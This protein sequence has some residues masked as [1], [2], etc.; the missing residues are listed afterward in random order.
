MNTRV[1]H[2]L[3]GIAGALGILAVECTPQQQTKP[4][5][6][7][8]LPVRRFHEVVQ[9]RRLDAWS[10]IGPGGGGTFYH[11]AIS[12][13]DPNLVFATTDMTQCF[14]S[15][16]GGQTWRQFNLRFTCRFAFDP[17]RPARVYALAGPAGLWRSDDRGHTWSLVYPEPATVAALWYLDDEGEPNIQSV[18]GYPTG[19]SAFAVDPEDSDTLY[20]VMPPDLQISRDAGKHWKTLVTKAGAQTIY[21]D[22]R[23]PRGNRTLY[24]VTGDST[25]VWDGSKY[26]GTLKIAGSTW[27]YGTGFGTPTRGGKSVLYTANDYVVRNGFLQSGGILASEDGGVTWR[28]LN[29]GLLKLVAPGTYPEFSALAAS[30]HHPE[31]IYVSFYH[32]YLPNDKNPYFGV[33]KT[34]DGGVTW[35]VVR[36]E[37]GEAADNMHDSWMTDRFGPDFGDQPLNIAVD[38][39][40]PDLVYTSD[41]GRLMRST[42]GGKSWEAVYSQGAANGYTTTGLDVATCYGLH[43]DPFDPR[44]MFISYTDIGLFRSLDGS[45]SWMSATA[46]GVP[47]AWRNTTYWVEFDPAVKG[48]MWAAMSGTHDLPRLRMFHKP[49]ATANMRGGVMESVD[50]G[51]TWETA[52]RGLPEMA[53]THILLDPKSD[54]KS[55]VLYVTGF[56]RGVFKSS[57]GGQSWTAKSR[58]LPAKEPLTWRMAMD[59]NGVLYMVT[60]RRSQDGTYGG[61]GDGALYRSRDGAETWERVPVPEGLNGPM[62]I[63]PDPRDADRLYLAAWGRY[64]QYASG[65]PAPLGGV[66]LS[67][68]GGRHWN[69]VL[70]ASRRIYDVTLDPRNPDVVYATGFE[71]S[72]WRSADRGKTWRRI[73]GFNFKHGHRVIPDPVDASKIYI[74]TFGSSVWHGPAEGDPRAVEDIVGPKAM[75]FGR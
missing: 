67:T 9:P 2:S 5:I 72:A 45:E 17:H 60:V 59:R 73:R 42:N 28:S 41:L 51:D 23:S 31:V 66:F 68:D 30:L 24:L 44:R 35:K 64:K 1:L 56:G 29:D 70:D 43:F 15:E 22:P 53:A 54:P 55:R 18:S 21:V 46:N 36:I 7:K 14:V 12:P 52:G 20:A 58:G 48:R 4:E 6:R 27:F 11:P 34:V 26:T 39:N 49:G 13:H 47:R 69:N 8:E 71:A 57:D 37:S 3:C 63:T 62:G 38:E 40:N 16:D 19:M 74:T 61:D 32:W 50:G 75:M 25:G 65:K 10:I 33:A